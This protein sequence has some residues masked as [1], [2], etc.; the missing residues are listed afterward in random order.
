EKGSTG[1]TRVQEGEELFHLS[2]MSSAGDKQ[3]DENATA[4]YTKTDGLLLAEALGI[5]ASVLQAI[6]NA[7]GLDQVQAR[8]MN[9]ALFPATLGYWLDTQLLPAFEA[10]NI[11]AI[12]R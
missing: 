11:A 2:R 12:P 3:F 6:P 1:W 7:D 8:A 9:T 5:D 4:P 10:H